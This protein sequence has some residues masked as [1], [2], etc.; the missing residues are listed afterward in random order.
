[1]IK[2]ISVNSTHYFITK[3]SNKQELQLI[4]F[5]HSSDIEFKDFFN[6]HKR[7]TTKPYSFI[8]IDAILV[9]DNPLRFLKKSFRKNIKTNH[10][11]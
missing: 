5:N 10:D 2:N 9:S 1:M 6:L 7:C 8:V 4:Q 3:L 11:N